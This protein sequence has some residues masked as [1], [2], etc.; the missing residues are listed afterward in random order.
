MTE[1][2][3]ENLGQ[4]NTE[5]IDPRYSQIDFL[6]TSELLKLINE[7]DQ[8][9]SLSVGKVLPQIEQ[10]ILEITKRMSQG[11]RLIYVGA[12]TS[13]RLGVLDASECI[14]TFSIP[15]GVV[16]GLIAGGDAA[17]RKGIEGAEDN[18][19]GAIPELRK[20]DLS[21]QDTVVGI[22]A[23]GRTPYA[24]GAMEFARSVGALSVALT[25]NPNSEMAKYAD[26]AIEID[27][28]PEILAGSTRMKAGTAQKLVL[29]MISTVTMINLGKT[30]GNLMVDLQVTN[31][32]LR[33]RAIRIIQAA[34]QVDAKRAEAALLAANNQVKV[35]IVMLLLQV[36]PT[37]AISALES[38]NSR[39]REA[40]K[41]QQ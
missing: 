15:D 33:D 25:C 21:K 17:L 12:G 19:D 4:L 5:T 18:R 24:I 13:G 3:K 37:E 35:A 31:V 14:P 22:A 38:A 28:G 36:T 41:P 39:V 2:Q 27:S 34:T 11:G 29:N 9:V 6:T 30:F 20:L 26:V 23:S 32:K 8:G 1:S 7:N 10:A 16:I 40:L